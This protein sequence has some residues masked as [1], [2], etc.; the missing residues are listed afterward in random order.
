MEEDG[1]DNGTDNGTEVDEIGD[2][3]PNTGAPPTEDLETQV[4][5]EEFDRAPFDRAPSSIGRNRVSPYPNTPLTPGGQEE[6][7]QNLNLV[8]QLAIGS[9]MFGPNGSHRPVGSSEP[10]GPEQATP[11]STGGQSG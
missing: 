4:V 2:R 8:Q 10:A 7:V 5:V 3:D 11:A 9:E 1:D 6:A